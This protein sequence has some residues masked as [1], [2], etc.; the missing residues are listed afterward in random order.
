V[1]AVV[2]AAG[3]AASAGA[4]WLAQ[5]RL[6]P[7]GGDTEDDFA[8]EGLVVP[9]EVESRFVTADGGARL[10]VLERGEGRPVVLLHG[11]ALSGAIWVRQLADA[12]G[13]ARAVRLVALDLR[14]HGRSSI[15]DAGFTSDGA[16]GP[17]RRM[18]QDVAIVLERLDLDD[19]VL[20]GHSMGGMV[21]QALVA[22]PTIEA[23]ARVGALALVSTASHPVV[24]FP[25]MRLLEAATAPL[26]R[27]WLSRREERGAELLPPSDFRWWAL[28]VAF[29]D[30]PRVA[31]VRY[32]E[33]IVAST[34]PRTISELLVA[35]SAF[36]A[37]PRLG[38][39]QMPAVVVVGT[40]DRLTPP[41]A[42]HRL[43]AELVDATLVELPGCG[44]MPM[45]ERAEELSGVILELANRRQPA[46]A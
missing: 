27:R 7:R 12:K 1:R 35:V 32:A 21:A 2:L 19:V 26:A 41:A 5:H 25:G 34:S 22:D 44:H 23:R 24:G 42:A 14:G 4:A 6:V 17:M 20:V 39:V 15:G 3:A 45:L 18:A 36:E 46:T 43:V 40:K 13:L 9:E 38:S 30:A 37:S 10:H 29:G 16:G 11:I 33:R 31:A 8:R 28:R